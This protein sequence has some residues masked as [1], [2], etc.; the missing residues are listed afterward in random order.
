MAEYKHRRII[1][2][3]GKTGCGKSHL[4]KTAISDCK[5]LIILD[6]QGEYP[7]DDYPLH[8]PVTFIQFDQYKQYVRDHVGDSEFCIICRFDEIE[9]YEAAIEIAYHAEQLT[10]VIEEAHNFGNAHKMSPI[11]ERIIRLGR[12]HCITVVGVSQRLMDMHTLA[13][14]NADCIV[15]FALTM[16]A[17]IK[18]LEDVPWIGVEGA[19]RVANLAKYEKVIFFANSA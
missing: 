13:R 4:V 16:P 14:S 10:I 7:S 6:I 19:A 8:N 3:V 12:H 5:R 18:Y 2:V 15:C 17:D 1:L 9:E 11:F